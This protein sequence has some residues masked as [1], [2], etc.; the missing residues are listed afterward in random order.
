MTWRAGRQCNLRAVPGRSEEAAESKAPESRSLEALRGQLDSLDDQI[1]RLLQERAAVS[2][3]VGK[4]KSGDESAPI[5]VPH[6]E[7]E[8]LARVQSVRGPLSEEALASI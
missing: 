5:F 1:A 2:Q 6:R 8:V 4:T 3:E 7:A